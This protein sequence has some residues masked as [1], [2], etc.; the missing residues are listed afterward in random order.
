MRYGFAGKKTL[1]VVWYLAGVCTL[2]LLLYFGYDLF[3]SNRLTVNHVYVKQGGLSSALRGKVALQI[4]DIHMKGIGDMERDVLKVIE[5]QK[6]DLLFLTGDYV[7]WNNKYEPALGFLAH[8]KAKTAVYAVLGDYDYSNS[9]KSCLFCHEQGSGQPTRR[10]QVKFLRDTCEMVV[11]GK[12][13]VRICGID[14]AKSDESI[15]NGPKMKQTLGDDKPTIVLSHSPLALENFSKDDDVL[16][17]AGDTH[18]GQV[19]LPAWVWKLLGYKKNAK[20]EQGWFEEGKKKMYVSR[21]LGTSHFPIRFMRPPEIT[22]FHFVSTE[23]H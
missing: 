5:A 20:Y 22:V 17:L 7:K 11:I 18:G 16:I 23:V 10:H 8:L 14:G 2:L 12:S 1:S 3:C 15:T 9:R 13:S 6:P 4:T 19:P 21:G